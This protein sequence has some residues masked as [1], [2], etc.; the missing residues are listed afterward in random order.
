MQSVPSS[1]CVHACVRSSSLAWGPTRTMPQPV[2]FSF[3]FPEFVASHQVKATAEGK[4][5]S[6]PSSACV[7]ACGVPVPC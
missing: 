5:Q 4:M 7:H 6:V 2:P 1:A 3:L